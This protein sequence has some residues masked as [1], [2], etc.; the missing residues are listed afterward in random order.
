MM[1]TK[2]FCR[3]SEDE[4]KAMLRSRMNE[5]RFEHSLNVAKRAVLLAEKNG[6]DPEKA[7]FAVLFGYIYCACCNFPDSFKIQSHFIIP[8]QKVVLKNMADYLVRH[9]GEEE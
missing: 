3:F 8:R 1:D 4:I 7:Y 2:K 9:L 5:H 6:A